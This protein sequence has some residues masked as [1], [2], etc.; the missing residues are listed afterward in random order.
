MIKG[1]VLSQSDD[2]VT[3][4]SS[5][6]LLTIKKKDLTPESR[7]SLELP[8]TDNVA[9]L[10]RRLFEQETVIEAL[11]A[12]NQAL[13]AMLSQAPLTPHQAVSSGA[14][15]QQPGGYW[16]SSTG[17]RHNSSCRYFGVGNGRPCSQQ[18]GIA[19]KIC[20]G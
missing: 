4:E 15:A 9:E 12:E 3:V 1:R 8:G 6:G 10:R 18:E 20:G 2:D 16:Y 7:A 11:R 19:C 5:L 13:R 17:K 14:V